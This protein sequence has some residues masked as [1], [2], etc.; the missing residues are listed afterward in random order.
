MQQLRVGAFITKGKKLL[1]MYRFK[2][3]HGVYYAIPGGKVEQDETLHQALIREIKEET[4]LDIEIGEPVLEFYNN[5]NDSKQIYFT[6]TT[7]TGEPE[8]IGP[9]HERN[10]ATNQYQLQWHAFKQLAALNIV[11]PLV[12][13]HVCQTYTQ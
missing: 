3:D 10:N 11:P 6:V 2:P 4:N 8:I 1:L 5:F 13:K 12:K 7:F 9:E